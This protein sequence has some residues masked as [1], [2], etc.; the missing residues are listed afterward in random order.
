MDSIIIYLYGKKY[1]FST[2]I[3]IVTKFA[4]CK[5]IPTPSSYWSKEALI[6]FRNVYTYPVRV[7]VIQT[8]NG[9]E[10]LGEFNLY[11]TKQ[12]IK[13]EF[14]YPR[15]PKV[16]GVVGRFNRTTQESF[17]KDRMELAMTINYSNKN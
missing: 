3:D 14:I 6:E 12:N 17:F 13:H 1:C 8:D 16:N 10:F 5:L 11:T 2:I 7:I 4:W 9:S 15:P